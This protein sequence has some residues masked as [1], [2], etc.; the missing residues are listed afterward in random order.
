MLYNLG[1]IVLYQKNFEMSLGS[2]KKSL[3]LNLLISSRN[4]VTV[5]VTSQYCESFGRVLKRLNTNMTARIGQAQLQYH[6]YILNSR[7]TADHLT[8]IF[9]YINVRMGLPIL[10]TAVW[11]VLLMFGRSL[12]WNAEPPSS[13]IDLTATINTWYKI[14][15]NVMFNGQTLVKLT[16]KKLYFRV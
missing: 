15:I 16:P 5:S 7:Y 13:N 2:C 14:I 4:L 10:V 1:N 12:N 3:H 8:A 9:A 6:F 11:Y